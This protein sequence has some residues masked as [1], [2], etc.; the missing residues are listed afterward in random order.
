MLGIGNI[1][2]LFLWSDLELLFSNI[3]Q[4]RSNYTTIFDKDWWEKDKLAVPVVIKFLSLYRFKLFLM[5][6]KKTLNFHHISKIYK[7]KT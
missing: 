4:L 1:L 3:L 7:S 6:L 5:K 2:C